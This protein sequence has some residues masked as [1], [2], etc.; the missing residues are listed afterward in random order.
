ME[1]PTPER[2]GGG[3][4]TETYRDLV[5]GGRPNPCMSPLVPSPGWNTWAFRTHGTHDGTH[6]GHTGHA[7]FPGEIL[8]VPCFSAPTFS[9]PATFSSP[10]LLPSPRSFPLNLLRKP[11]ELD[12]K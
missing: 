4:A 1:K 6:A 8:H 10:F 11:D 9:S 3:E 5:G 7:R 2:Q 12:N